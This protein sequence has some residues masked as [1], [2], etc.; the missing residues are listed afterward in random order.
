MPTSTRRWPPLTA[1][2]PPPPSSGRAL[3]PAPR[4]EVPCADN[5]ALAGDVRRACEPARRR[6][7]HTDPLRPTRCAGLI[8]GST[9][10][11]GGW[12]L[13][14][15][16]SRS[17]RSSPIH[18]VLQVLVAR[19]APSASRRCPG[20]EHLPGASQLTPQGLCGWGQRCSLADALPQGH[21]G[22]PR[23]TVG[24]LG[25]PRDGG[26]AHDHVRQG[27]R[28]TT[29]LRTVRGPHP[30]LRRRP[31]LRSPG[32]EVDLQGDLHQGGFLPLRVRPSR[33]H[34]HAGKVV[35]RP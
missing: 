19:N 18:H 15:A 29:G 1:T 17:S 25:R 5:E 11:G 16:N 8:Q 33:L 32:A 30:L 7:Q 2:G 23:R 6:Q 14:Y 31:Q 21:G 28:R 34:G 13:R 10:I 12:K 27:A 26:A 20:T 9:R 35:V 3:S 24:Q 22:G 4:S